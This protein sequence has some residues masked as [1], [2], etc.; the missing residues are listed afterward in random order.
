MFTD[1]TNVADTTAE[2]FLQKPYRESVP[3][4][5][6]EGLEERSLLAPLLLWRRGRG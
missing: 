5:E 6:G 4:S 3:L 2:P 1:C